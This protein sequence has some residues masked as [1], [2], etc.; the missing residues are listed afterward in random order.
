MVEVGDGGEEGGSKEGCVDA[1]VEGMEE[2]DEEVED[3][4]EERDSEDSGARYSDEG[5]LFG[6]MDVLPRAKR[7]RKEISEDLGL[8]TVRDNIP[9]DEFERMLSGRGS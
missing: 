9:D 8:V 1:E 2:E 4:E 6:N 3:S 7:V 5:G